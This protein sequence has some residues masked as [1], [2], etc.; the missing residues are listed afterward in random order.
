MVF[1]NDLTTVWQHFDND[2]TTIWQHFVRNWFTYLK[3]ATAIAM[4]TINKWDKIFFF[5]YSPKIANELK[6]YFLKKKN[7]KSCYCEV[8]PLGGGV[9]MNSKLGARIESSNID[10]VSRV[11]V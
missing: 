9:I 6:I 3:K 4:W 8:N 11:Q 7:L 1:D 2:L 10:L 5:S